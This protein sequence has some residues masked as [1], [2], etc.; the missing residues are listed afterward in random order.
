[1]FR[2]LIRSHPY[3]SFLFFFPTFLLTE[4]LAALAVYAYFVLR[5]TDE[6][7]EEASLKGIKRDFEDEVEDVEDK[8]KEQAEE[9]K[10][11]IKQEEEEEDEE[12]T[13]EPPSVVTE[14]E[15]E[16]LL[17]GEERF[18]IERRRERLAREAGPGGKGMSE[19]QGESL[20]ETSETEE[21]EEEQG[22]SGEGSEEWEGVAE[23]GEETEVREKDFDETATIGGVRLTLFFLREIEMGSDTDLESCWGVCRARRLELPDRHSGLRLQRRARRGP[24]LLP[25]RR[26]G[27]MA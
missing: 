15:E 23:A 26:E 18:R 3:L 8:V 14:T 6:Q 4:L 5:P 24:R 7:S 22:E 16:D 21:T 27:R 19:I 9:I 20:T 25:L 1:M 13:S 12:T 11:E 2:A 17:E 10:R